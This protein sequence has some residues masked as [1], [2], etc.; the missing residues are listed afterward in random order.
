[1]AT[2][3]FVTGQMN[4]A[5]ASLNTTFANVSGGVANRHSLKVTTGESGTV[6]VDVCGIASQ[7]PDSTG[8]TI[9]LRVDTY[10]NDG[11]TWVNSYVTPSLYLNDI[12][13]VAGNLSATPGNIGKKLTAATNLPLYFRTICGDGLTNT[14]NRSIRMTLKDVITDGMK[15][16][17]FSHFGAKGADLKNTTAD[18]SMSRNANNAPQ[19]LVNAGPLGADQGIASFRVI[20]VKNATTATSGDVKVI[21][22]APLFK[23]AGA[24]I[25]LSSVTFR[26]KENSVD[27]AETFVELSSSAS[28]TEQ[29]GEYI[30][31][32]TT[33]TSAANKSYRV[34]A[35]AVQDKFEVYGYVYQNST[36]GLISLDNKP[37]KITETSIKVDADASGKDMNTWRQ[38]KR[39]I[40]SFT[41]P[42]VSEGE[43]TI[44]KYEA[45]WVSRAQAMSLGNAQAN[46]AINFDK[47]AAAY[48]NQVTVHTDIC[49]TTGFIDRNIPLTLP[50]NSVMRSDGVADPA[51]RYAVF[52]CA[53]TKDDNGQ[54][55][56][57]AI[58]ADIC[59]NDSF[60]NKSDT[61]NSALVADSSTGFFVSGT[62][63][64][65][66]LINVRTGANKLLTTTKTDTSAEKDVSM[67]NK[68]LLTFNNYQVD[69]RGS[70]YD[71]LRYAVIRAVDLPYANSLADISFIQTPITYDNDAQA[72]LFD[73]SGSRVMHEWNATNG[74]FEVRKT[75][76]R[77]LSN[78]EEFA[79]AFA[80][81]NSNGMG[82]RTA[83]TTFIPSSHPDTSA[84]LYTLDPSRDALKTN[85]NDSA[86]GAA[87]G[88]A[89]ILDNSTAF[90][91]SPVVGKHYNV[92]TN[93][94]SIGFGFSQFNKTQLALKKAGK[95]YA[96]A[97]LL[98]GGNQ[99]T[100]IRYYVNKSA[101]HG[102]DA[103]FYAIRLYGQTHKDVS[104]TSAVPTANTKVQTVPATRD[105]DRLV[106]S[107]GYDGSGNITNLK[108]GQRYDICFGLV[109]ENGSNDASMCIV[110]GFAPVGDIA[111][112]RNLR[113]GAATVQ[114]NGSNQATFDL[115]FSDLSGASQHGGNLITKYNVNVTQYQGELSGD[116]V[117]LKDFAIENKVS[118]VNGVLT[119]LATRGSGALTCNAATALP[120]YPMK[121]TV[122]GEAE[123][124]ASTTASNNDASHSNYLRLGSSSKKGA[125]ATI[126][127]PGPKLQTGNVHD[128]VRALLVTAADS[129]LKVSF[130]K[131]ESAGVRD[132]YQ[133]TP[134][135]NA[136]HI[137]QYDMSL[138][139][140]S[141]RLALGRTV[142]VI[143]DV[144]DL[145]A[146][147]L[148][149]EL[150]GINGKA[151]VVAVHT[152][153]RY[154]SNND[155]L[156]LSKGVYH[157]NLTSALAAND[158]SY[159]AATGLWTLPA[160][161]APAEGFSIDNLRGKGIPRGTPKIT[162]TNNS[163]RF[164]NNGDELT[165]GAMIQVAPKD[166][167]P[168]TQAA[169]TTAFYLDLCG[170]AV[171][172]S[173]KVTPLKVGVHNTNR[174]TYDICS[175]TILGA[176]WANEQNFVVVQNQA[177]SAYVKINIE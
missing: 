91:T 23:G 46:K 85:S 58:A 33:V 68:A 70:N 65:P 104:G 26:V 101:A 69:Q 89:S 157:S 154:G 41:A 124:L 166:G 165:V 146:D 72:E 64:A 125:K 112:V 143:T 132:L 43:K 93:N 49:S 38:G 48:P 13:T 158:A 76:L 127:V 66:T 36:N 71:S 9:R 27:G 140:L 128:D 61:G 45:R 60:Y 115:S 55:V 151:Y 174:K 11:T 138:T 167:N 156:Q 80:F 99:T 63:A 19:V 120:G 56:K 152:Q 57:G 133:G 28:V 12:S 82:Q 95:S 96:A 123:V 59:A 3:Y 81:D 144:N 100:G 107:Q 51:S 90:I 31:P 20:M 176:N 87:F 102:G 153:W 149:V 168:S 148:D 78:G 139:G 122:E 116:V 94:N 135:I 159:A 47:I 35:T 170:T 88:F 4:K 32:L 136:Y 130:Y 16:N 109:N 86:F 155:T 164:D 83:W 106:V 6:Y 98:T 150:D 73:L 110:R 75:G 175:T 53:F 145:A 131:P 162:V 37:A 8:S 7:I 163:L 1:M 54:F 169:N 67:T 14:A 134:T 113:L 172:S 117:L 105:T 79:V 129:K 74:R 21:S 173:N 160:G 119:N 44:A 15:V 77:D 84:G 24:G 111:A 50:S 114:L 22:S 2:S 137:Y 147:K 42:A 10:E 30:Y 5:D 142:K 25:D 177:G 103:N 161:A 40:V 17:V 18:I 118:G 62:P 126:T 108:L 39:A 29:D 121:I 171:S 97:E 52:L 34:V 92:T 141:N